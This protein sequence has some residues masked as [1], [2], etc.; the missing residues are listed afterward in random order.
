MSTNKYVGESQ[1]KSSPQK[2][3]SLKLKTGSVTTDKIAAKAVTM[4][5]LDDEVFSKVHSDIKD[6]IDKALP[7]VNKY[8]EGIFNVS[9]YK[10]VND[11]PKYY[12]TL[13]EALQDVPIE[14]RIK[15]LNI[16]FLNYS[17]NSY[18]QYRLT[19]SVWSINTDNW[20][21]VGVPKVI[22]P[23]QMDN[24]LIDGAPN[25]LTDAT[26]VAVLDSDGNPIE[27]I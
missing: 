4:D 18:K 20:L 27:I 6:A 24:V 9:K 25:Y 2:A 16:L 12:N 1:I 26:G 5:K 22:T 15:G 19:A 7:S 23:S 11:V 21:E 3:L 10:A 14:K 8:S 13:S 17:D